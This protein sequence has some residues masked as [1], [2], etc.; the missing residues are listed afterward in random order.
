MRRPWLFTVVAIIGA[1]MSYARPCR[2]DEPSRFVVHEWGVLVLG[3]SEAGTELG[4][5]ERLPAGLPPFVLRHDVAYKPKR[6]DHGWNK[7]VIYFYGPE[8]L[9]VK[10][11]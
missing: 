8:G 9:G 11:A 5:P 7:P 2:A 3:R 6:Q 1:S 10:V 4:P